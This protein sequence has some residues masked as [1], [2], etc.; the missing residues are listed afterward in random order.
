M[1]ET[2]RKHDRME[3]GHT[4]VYRQAV[5]VFWLLFTFVCMAVAVSAGGCGKKKIGGIEKTPVLPIMIP[6]PSPTPTPV[7]TPTST[8]SP[9]PAPDPYEGK[10]Q[11]MLTGEWIPEEEKEYRPFAVML[12]NIKVASPQ[13]GI[14][15]ADI[16]YEALTEAGITRFLAIYSEIGEDTPAAE[17]LGSVRSARHYFVSFAD[18]Y[19]AIFVHFGETTYAAKKMKKL[20]IDHITG[21]YGAGVASFYRDNTIKAPHNAFASLK[22]IRTGVE[23]AGFRTEYEEGYESHFRFYAEDTAPYGAQDA[24]AADRLTLGFSAYMAPYFVYDPEAGVYARFQFDGEHTDYNTKEQ[25]TFK[26]LIIQLVDEWNIDKN[27]YQ[28]MDIEDAEGKGYYITN[29]V[30]VPV[31]WRKNESKRFMRYY[32]ENGEEL[33][34]NPGKTYIA[35]FPQSREKHIAIEQEGQQH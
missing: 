10:K 23:R 11:S 27:G 1:R 32:D 16:V 14:G 18:E 15:Q 31:T 30:C 7:P 9:T 17:R 5:P 28:T 19:D 29:G 12:N 24:Q 34:I 6:V 26:N 35:V 33:T 4:G 8:P 20:G 22:G 3:N 13:S 21:M 2:S 25:L